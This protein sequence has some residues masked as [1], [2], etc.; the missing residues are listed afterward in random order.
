MTGFKISNTFHPVGIIVPGLVIAQVIAAIQVYLSNMDLYATVAA[1]NAAGYLAIPNERVMSSLQNFPAAFFGGLFFSLSI[2]AGISL[3]TMAAVWIWARVF[4]RNKF[5]LLIFL[6]AWG[7]MLLLVNI[8]GFT[9]FPTL[10]FLLIPPVIFLLTARRE[11][12][13]DIPSIQIQRLMHLIPIPLLAVLWFTQFDNEMFLDLRDNLLLSNFFGKKFSNFYYTYTLYPAEAFKSLDQKVIKTCR[14]ENISNPSINLKLANR[15]MAYGY[16]LLPGEAKVDL[17]II[18][19][20][21]N[22]L[23][24]A[25]GRPIFQIQVNQFLLDSKKVLRSY[26]IKRDCCAIFRQITFLSLLIG[27][28]LLIYMVL[29]AVFYYLFFL[30]LG[31]KRAALTASMLCLLMGISVFVYFQS[32]RSS[33]I[34]I[35]DISGA[36]KSENWHSRVAALKVIQHK[37]M[38]VA[39]YQAY[40]LLLNSQ[41]PQERYWFVKTL[42][43]S[44]RP[45]TFHD[46]LTFLNDK[47]TNIRSMAFL[48]LGLRKNPQAIKPLLE[49]IKISDDWYTQMYAYKALRALG[50]KQTKSP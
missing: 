25:D 46:L 49:K 45:E 2:G 33:S 19:K 12:D 15:L 48:S 37:K 22:L 40:P 20:D 31:R 8:H 28:P 43:F 11:T 30:F 14:L 42:A 35:S 24:Q 5:I 41:V 9:W 23:F 39:D 4:L 3:G 10:Y 38:D 26:S 6:F 27:F 21:E 13:A 16:L 44:R 47:N 34:Q 1:A 18:Q 32:N 36:L 17:K 50:W 7:A 29:H